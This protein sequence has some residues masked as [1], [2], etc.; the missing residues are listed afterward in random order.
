MVSVPVCDE[1]SCQLARIELCF[2][3]LPLRAFAAVYKNI[4]VL[5]LQQDRTMVALFCRNCLSSAQ[6]N[7]IYLF[8]IRKKRRGFLL[9]ALSG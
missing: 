7:N 6:E 4:L 3:E 5:V 1:D 9:F 2:S 8:H